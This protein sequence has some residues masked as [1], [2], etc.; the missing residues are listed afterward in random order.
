MSSVAWEIFAPAGISKAFQSRHVCL[1]NVF[2]SQIHLPRW[3]VAS[4][5]QS[6]AAFAP[7]SSAKS[8]T[9]DRRTSDSKTRPP[10]LNP[11]HRKKLKKDFCSRRS[12]NRDSGW[13]QK[14]LQDSRQT[15]NYAPIQTTSRYTSGCGREITTALTST[16]AS[17][18]TARPAATPACTE[19]TSPVMEQNALP[20]IAIASRTSSSCTDEDF[21]T[22]SAAW[23]SVAT[24]KD[25]ITPSAPLVSAGCVRPS[26]TNT[27]GWRLAMTKLSMRQPPAAAVPASTAEV[28]DAVSPPMSTMYLPEQI[29]RDK[30]SRTLPAFNIV[31]ATSKPAAMLDSSIKPTDFSAIKLFLQNDLFVVRLAHRARHRRVQNR[32]QR[33]RRGFADDLSEA[34]AVADFHLD[35][36]RRAGALLERQD[37]ATR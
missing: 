25:S 22:A 34:H 35:D 13:N 3:L 10:H 5:N 27:S 37:E 14:K 9:G 26:A 20:P 2:V 24:L 23:M 16:P 15:R 29:E 12:I 33:V 11:R 21:A 28:T 17:A 30:I 19:A 36:A 1:S 32:A 7:S 6:T 18:S 31:S 4:S 8:L